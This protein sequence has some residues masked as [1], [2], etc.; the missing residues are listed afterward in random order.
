VLNKTNEVSL[1]RYVDRLLQLKERRELV[2]EVASAPVVEAR[3]DSVI[4]PRGLTD[5]YYFLTPQ[6]W[7]KVFLDRESGQVAFDAAEVEAPTW[8][9]R[10]EEVVKA[11]YHMP[12]GDR[13]DLDVVYETSEL[14]DAAADYIKTYVT[15][16]G[17]YVA[18]A[19]VWALL[20]HTRHALP[21]SEL[22]IVRK[23]GFG[24]GGTTAAKVVSLISARPLRPAIMPSAAS[25]I[26]VF[27]Y[28]TPTFVLDE[29]RTEAGAEY[30][31][32][33]KLITESVYD[34]SNVTLRMEDK[35]LAVYSLYGNVIAVDTSFELTTLS[36]ERRA[37]QIRIE[38]D[39]NRVTNLYYAEKDAAELVKKLYAWGLAWPL[40]AR[41]Y[42]EQYGWFQGIGALLALK[43][44]LETRG[45]KSGVV[46]AAY[47]TVKKQL[48]ETYEAAAITDPVRRVASAIEDAVAEAREYISTRGTVPLGWHLSEDGQCLE[49]YLDTL[50]R[51]VRERLRYLHE[52]TVQFDR[53]PYGNLIENT[54]QTQWY[55]VDPEVE[56]L[57]REA[58]KF[59]A[60]LRTLGYTIY[61]DNS[62][63]YRVRIC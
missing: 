56:P 15:M 48:S 60:I 39:P 49:I 25:M 41:Q 29:V 54:R 46:E 47:E 51:K 9:P 23:S 24:S 61:Y 18:V 22:L 20:T 13:L 55:K 37:W 42:I 57:I 50:R 30:V 44:W 8:A 45:V 19:A 27:H 1:A 21:Y 10:I 7:R 43:T 35:K 12:P 11:V 40:I 31:S 14:L 4:Y 6:G 34:A 16:R 62:R 52:I 36:S 32:L 17:E 26:R 2:E 63:N 5:K 28:L 53:D 33:L 3:V 58:R 59:L 38:R